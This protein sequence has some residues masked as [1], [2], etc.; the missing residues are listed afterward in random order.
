MCVCEHATLFQLLQMLRMHCIALAP[1]MLPC[2]YLTSSRSGL[3]PDRTFSPIQPGAD[4]WVPLP[5]PSSHAFPR[6]ALYTQLRGPS[7]VRMAKEAA[8]V[9]KASVEK[10]GKAHILKQRMDHEQPADADEASASGL[11]HGHVC[12]ICP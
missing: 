5:A 1:F 8:L 3:G 9:L 6:L 7:V 4:T 12:V 11:L 10:E 2:L